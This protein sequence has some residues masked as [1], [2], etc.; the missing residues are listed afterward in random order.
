MTQRIFLTV[1]LPEHLIAKYK[2]SFAACNFSFNLMSGEGFDNVYSILPLYVGGEMGAEAFHDS[3]F[4]LV[5]DK[6]RK[7]GGIWQK[8]AVLKEQWTVFK[9]IPKGSSIWF[10]NLTTLNAFLFILLKMFKRSVQ[11]NVIVLDF[12]TINS[13]FGLN[14]IYL[15]MINDAHGRLCL[16]NSS[17]FKKENAAILPGVVPAHNE[18]L[19][20]VEIITHK[21]LL[22]G[23]LSEEIAQTSM[24]LEA[25]SMLPKCEL[26]IT[27]SHNMDNVK[28]YADKYSNIFYYEQLNYA[29]YLE[30][31]HSITFQLSTRDATFPE[32][33]CNFPSKIIEA[34]LHNRAIVSTIQYPQ[35]EGINYFKVASN[36]KEF[37]RDIEKMV[38]ISDDELKLY[39]NQGKK[40]KKMFST[41]VWNKVM[42][43]IENV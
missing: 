22:S 20:K 13:G 1:I 30:L 15:K 6:L 24:V 28:E 34:L 43:K 39:V 7:K 36:V 4:E 14:S 9:K 8:L 2:L 17:L 11:L 19:P 29:D 32:N 23:M 18:H 31:L 16:A 37:I 33:Q 5:Y 3:R 10:Y 27:G 35:L 12:T 21:F 41:E 40:V 38:S 42:L 26:H 25:F